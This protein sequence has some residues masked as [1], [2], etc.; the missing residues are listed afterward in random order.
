MK[1]RSLFTLLILCGLLGCQKEDLILTG[2]LDVTFTNIA[3]MTLKP[4]IYQLDNLSYPLF[5]DIFVDTNGNMT[6]DN[7]NYGNYVIEYFIHDDLNGGDFGRR[8]AF[9]INPDK[10]TFLRIDL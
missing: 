1:L 6:K 10:T 4:K 9:Q 8:V 5:E 3:K 7:L 2:Q